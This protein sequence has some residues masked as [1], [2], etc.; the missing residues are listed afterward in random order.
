MLSVAHRM[1]TDLQ[2]Y[3]T[4]I[5]RQHGK[6]WKHY[7]EYY[8][9]KLEELRGREAMWF[10][11]QRIPVEDE[12]I[13]L[14]IREYVTTVR[15]IQRREK[16]QDYVPRSYFYNCRGSCE[17]HD[18]CVAEF[19]GLEIEPLIRDGFRFVGERYTRED[20]LSG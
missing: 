13:L 5:K 9:P 7:L 11:R 14:A 10:D 18:P 6:Q 15:D 3:F 19:Q 2:T 4:A 20:L 8:R 12:R 1:D 16:R 17:Y